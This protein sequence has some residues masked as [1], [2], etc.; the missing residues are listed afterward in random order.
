M[1][2]DIKKKSEMSHIY[3]DFQPLLKKA[4]SFPNGY[5]QLELRSCCLLSAGREFSLH[6]IPASLPPSFACCVW[7]LQASE[8]QTQ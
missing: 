2:V 5:K 6:H 8:F 4:A 7:S 1:F 3:L